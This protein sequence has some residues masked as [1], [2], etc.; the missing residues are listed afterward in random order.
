MAGPVESLSVAVAG[1]IAL[2]ALNL[3]LRVLGSR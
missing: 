1:S 2:Y 3:G